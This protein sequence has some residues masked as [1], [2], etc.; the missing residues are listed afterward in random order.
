MTP[1][2]VA[3]NT[4]IMGS[5]VVVAIL[6]AVLLWRRG[7]GISSRP[8]VLELADGTRLSPGERE[9]VTSAQDYVVAGDGETSAQEL[10]TEVYPDH[11]VGYRTARDWWRG[12]VGPTLD[13]ATDLEV[14]HDGRRTG[15]GEDATSP[16]GRETGREDDATRRKDDENR[17]NEPARE[18]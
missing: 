18:R 4:V 8:D 13:Q 10:R 17:Q 1:L 6:V 5:L 15:R 3:P 11:R 2:Q 14:P 9:A 7:R 12:L 16:T